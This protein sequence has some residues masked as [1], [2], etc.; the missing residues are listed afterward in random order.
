MRALVAGDARVW[1]LAM[2]A[3]LETIATLRNA[4]QQSAQIAAHR[5]RAA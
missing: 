3:D 5:V 1:E 2:S 4:P